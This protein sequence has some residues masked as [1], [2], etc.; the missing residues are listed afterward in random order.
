MTL[1]GRLLLSYCEQLSGGT[2]T[3]DSWAMGD[4]YSGTNAAKTYTQGSIPSIQKTSGLLDS[5]GRIFGKSHPQY[6]SY[7]TDQFIS[8][9][10]QGAAGDG[11]TDDTQAIKNVFAQVCL[12]HSTNFRNDLFGI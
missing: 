1:Y 9:K 12:F 4:T 8:V 3:I 7:G 6:A 5:T 2:T 10:S 11:H